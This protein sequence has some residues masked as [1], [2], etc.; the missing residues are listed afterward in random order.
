LR[1]LPW[2]FNARFQ[3]EPR[4]YEQGGARAETVPPGY[5]LDFTELAA[6]YGWEQLPAL[7]NWRSVYSAARF[8]E[9]VR[10]DGLA[11]REAMLELYPPEILVTPTP[12]PTATN[13]PTVTATA[14]PTITPTPYP[15][16][17]Q[18]PT[19]TPSPTP[20][21]SPTATSFQTEIP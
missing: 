11:W 19:P 15:P 12:I 21:A 18:T 14:T 2:N 16:G 7:S 1:A 9:F 8:N 20:T 13:T 17:Y 3:G 10:R 4:P 6:A 5:W